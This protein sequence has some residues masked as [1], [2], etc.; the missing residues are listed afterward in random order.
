MR[1][2]PTVAAPFY[3][4]M[5]SIERFQSLHLTEAFEQREEEK[6]NEGHKHLL[7]NLCT[8]QCDT[9]NLHTVTVLEEKN[10]WVVSTKTQNRRMARLK[11][12]RT[13]SIKL[14]LS[15]LFYKQSEKRLCYVI[16]C[17]I[18]PIEVTASLGSELLSVCGI[19]PTLWKRR[20]R[21]T[22]VDFW[23]TFFKIENC[24]LKI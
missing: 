20:C 18:S 16:M 12:V 13:Q 3:Y 2:S 14:R 8:F 23:A 6:E 7:Q 19:K 15:L 24:Y 9:M 1:L 5:T 11:E 10:G 22:M 21:G 17:Y 4:P